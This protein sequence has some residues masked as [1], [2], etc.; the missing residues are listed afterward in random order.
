MRALLVMLAV[1]A[2][3]LVAATHASAHASCTSTITASSR[4]FCGPARA[5]FKVGGK[6]IHFN[7]GG[8]CS[9][10]SSTWTLN[11]GTIALKGK[12]KKAYFGITVFSKKPGKHGA[13]VTWQLHGQSHSLINAEVTLAKGLKKGTFTGTDPGVGKATGSFSCK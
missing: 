12:P 2:A 8:N 10:D 6:T 1:A 7:E 5:T 4:T 3:A 9:T 13:A 11:I